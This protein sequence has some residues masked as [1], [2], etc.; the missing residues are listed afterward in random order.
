MA[1]W[2]VY[3]ERMKSIGKLYDTY[4]DALKEFS[5]LADKM[6]EDFCFPMGIAG[7]NENGHKQFKIVAKEEEGWDVLMCNAMFAFGEEPCIVKIV[8][9]KEGG[10]A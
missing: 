10:N 3:F 5:Y 2:A 6:T 9:P 1:K 7:K 4:S 8:D